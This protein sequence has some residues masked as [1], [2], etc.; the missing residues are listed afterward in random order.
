MQTDHSWLQKPLHVWKPVSKDLLFFSIFL[1]RPSNR[2]KISVFPEISSIIHQHELSA[3]VME[4][5][6]FLV[7]DI[8]GIPETWMNE[9]TTLL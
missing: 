8:I 9:E 5:H 4:I 2:S 3:F 7:N 1:C 6:K